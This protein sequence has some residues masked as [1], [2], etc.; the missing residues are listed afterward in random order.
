MGQES[1][2]TDE[3]GSDEM[4]GIEAKGEMRRG[5]DET[6]GEEM[7]QE[8]ARREKRSLACHGKVVRPDSQMVD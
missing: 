6:L 7:I 1:R 8:E 5:T 2:G 4:R 3:A